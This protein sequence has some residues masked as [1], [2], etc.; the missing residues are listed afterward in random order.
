MFRHP[1]RNSSLRNYLRNYP[2]ICLAILIC[3]ALLFST[4]VIPRRAAASGANGQ[5]QAGPPGGGQK[6][7]PPR[8]I[9]GAPGVGL[10]NNYADS[11]S[12]GVNRN[13]FAYPT[14]ITA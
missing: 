6:V 13:T 3:L 12:D 9:E 1:S 11:F 8:P 5:G 7:D 2:P 14:A 10:P 4:L